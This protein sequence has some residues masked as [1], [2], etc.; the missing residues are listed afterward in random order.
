MTEV[1]IHIPRPHD[2]TTEHI[3]LLETTTERLTTLSPLPHWGGTSCPVEG[4]AGGVVVTPSS[5]VKSGMTLSNDD[6][7]H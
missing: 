1:A 6:S 7:D 4:T 5:P 3:I 2:Q